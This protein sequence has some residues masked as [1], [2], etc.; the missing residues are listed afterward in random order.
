M[1]MT[2]KPTN[3]LIAF[4]AP[5]L[6]GSFIHTTLNKVAKPSD[7]PESSKPVSAES[8]CDPSNEYRL[9]Q[10]G[11]WPGAIT[12]YRQY[13]IGGMLAFFHK[14]LFQS[15]PNGAAR[16]GPL[17]TAAHTNG[18]KLWLADDF[19]Y[20]SGMA[21]GMVVQ[22]NPAFEVRGLAMVTQSGNGRGATAIKLPAGAERFVSAVLYPVVNGLPDFTGGQTVSVGSMLIESTGLDGPW[23][24]CAFAT[25][26]RN[27]DVQ[28]QSTMEQFGHSGQYPDLMNREAVGR[29]LSLMHEPI[30]AEIDDL[31]SKVEGFYTNEP[32]LMQ[33]HWKPT[34]M[35]P[36]ACLPWN[37]KLPEKF[38]QMHGYDL[39]PLLGALYQGDGTEARRVRMHFQQTVAELLSVNFARQIREWCNAHGVHSSGHFLL[40]EHLCMHVANYGDYMKFVSEFDVPAIDTAIPNPDKIASFA[41]PFALFTSSVATWKERDKTMCLLDPIIGGGGHHRLSPAMPLLRNSVNMTCFHGISEFSS[42]TP[43]TASPDGSATGYTMEEY[44]AFNEYLGRICLL[45]RG[46][47][48]ATSV[49]LYYP[50]AMFQA[51][52]RPSAQHWT[53]I[54][55]PY[56]KRQRA[57]DDTGNALLQADIAFSIVHPEAVAQSAVANGTMKIGFGNYR[58]LVMPQVEFLPLAVLDKIK[59]FEAGG[60]TVLWVDTKPQT[61]AYAREDVQVAAALRET[62]VI[63]PADLAARITSPYPRDFNLR[64]QPGSESLAVARFRRENQPVYF[65]VNRTEKELTAHVQSD[66]SGR[67][68]VFDPATGTI[69]DTALPGE[70][71]IGSFGSLLILP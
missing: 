44:R 26:I 71:K 1:N 5:L 33:V 41:Y 16:I 24:L 22:E 32:N 18:Y 27:K 53:Q 59:A 23:Q 17:V 7:P 42:Y 9:M 68:K 8:F 46:A 48:P 67:V 3:C 70:L 25:V 4:F 14:D 34:T 69:Q 35:A 58:Y 11:L 38:R 51:D 6:I 57:W 31:P 37:D 52:F 21:G 63:H 54:L 50:I 13:G 49:A 55:S 64:F 65:L 61:G 2:A 45:L 12:K 29:F 40:D 62:P 19:G 60:G 30:A 15:G 20:P 28:A 39:L 66:S 56:E 43:L 36:F 10:Y 47:K